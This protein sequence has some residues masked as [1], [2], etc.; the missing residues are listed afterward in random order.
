MVTY[1]LLFGQVFDEHIEPWKTLM[2]ELRAEKAEDTSDATTTVNT[3]FGELTQHDIPVDIVVTPSRI[4]HVSNRLPMPFDVYWNLLSPQKLAH[5][6]VLQE[7]KKKTEEELGE[8]LPSGPKE[9]LPPT[10]ERKSRGG[11]GR[12][13]RGRDGRRRRKGAGRGK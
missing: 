9:V 2:K 10:A 13:G 5:I 11:R 3:P 4:I 6:R 8:I 1:P 7:L 12:D